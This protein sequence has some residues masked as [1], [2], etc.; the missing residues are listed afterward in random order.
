M[1][2]RLFLSLSGSL[3]GSITHVHTSE[4]LV[5]LTFDD[6]PH[7]MYTPKLLE[8]LAR[9]DARATFFMVGAAATRYRDVVAKVAEAGHAIG[10]HSW[11]HSFFPAIGGKERREEIRRCSRALAPYGEKLFRPP[12]GGETLSSHIDAFILGY[13]V[14]MLNC[15]VGDWWNP[16]S[17]VM[18]RGLINRVKPG[19]IVGLHD[20]LFKSVNV[21][22][23]VAHESLVDREPMLEALG[24][25]LEE[26]GRRFRFVTVP[27][28]L[29]HGAPQYQRQYLNTARQNKVVVG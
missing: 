23:G 27:E 24:M 26:C 6:G 2:E 1:L 19:A 16:D 13:Q 21:I 11:S 10:N 14:I 18:A 3:V 20:S 12:N 25:F 29:R 5:A 28:L 22:P 4:P 7:P 15:D 9:H 17:A 8:L